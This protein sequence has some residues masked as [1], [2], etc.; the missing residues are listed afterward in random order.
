MAPSKKL[1]LGSSYT[2]CEILMDLPSHFVAVNTDPT[3][4]TPTCGGMHACVCE[5]S[6]D[7]PS[8]FRPHS[9]RDWS[10]GNSVLFHRCLSII[11]WKLQRD[12]KDPQWVG[13]CKLTLPQAL[14]L[15]K[16][17]QS[18]KTE[19]W[20]CSFWAS[21]RLQLLAAAVAPLVS[22]LYLH[23]STSGFCL[24]WLRD[25]FSWTWLS[26]PLWLQW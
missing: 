5:L 24:W 10:M 23:G 3:S 4:L 21:E 25:S 17:H 1:I 7:Q 15:A 2:T 11:N 20:S 18:I 6:C 8:A 19:A 9:A 14:R 16:S 22:L 13:G 12:T 26:Y